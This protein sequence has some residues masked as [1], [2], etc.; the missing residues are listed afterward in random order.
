MSLSSIDGSVLVE[1]PSTL[2]AYPWLNKSSVTNGLCLVVTVVGYY[3]PIWSKPLFNTG[4]FAL[5][6][7]ITNW[8]AIY[9]L[10]EKIP[11][12]YGSGV[13]PMRFEEFKAGIHAMIMQQ[14]FTRDTM[15]RFFASKLSLGEG[16]GQI[17]LQEVIAALD[18]ELLYSKLVQAVQQSPLGPMLAMFGGEN[19]LTTIKEPFVA[20]MRDAL[21]DMANSPRFQGA[22]QT[23][24]LKA[25]DTD[26]VVTK[27]DDIVMARLAELTP[28]MVKDI[29]QEMIRQHLGWLVVWGGVFGGLIGLGASYLS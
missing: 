6:G 26:L 16:K 19:A 11:F 25:L 24:L 14:F 15:Q 27:I 22:L 28:A 3:S 21:L 1:K 9:M 8:L 10:F 2:A 13:I 4:I 12:L 29:I 17:D 18:Y 5:S 7:A 23:G 20:K